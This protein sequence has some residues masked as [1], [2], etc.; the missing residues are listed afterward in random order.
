MVYVT[1]DYH[2]QNGGTNKKLNFL[3]YIWFI[4][5][6]TLGLCWLCSRIGPPNLRGPGGRLLEFQV[7]VFYKYR[8]V[9]SNI[10]NKNIHESLCGTV[11]KG[12]GYFTVRARFEIALC[13]FSILRLLFIYFFFDLTILFPSPV[14]IFSFLGALNFFFLRLFSFSLNHNSILQTKFYSTLMHFY[15][16]LMKLLLS[17]FSSSLFPFPLTIL[18]NPI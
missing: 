17:F 4:S 18:H 14:L 7:L 15:I 5:E 16:S 12:Q 11:G 10:R 2:G 9:R 8:I 6:P 1:I 3:W 13:L